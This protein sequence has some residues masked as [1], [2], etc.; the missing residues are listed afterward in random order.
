M[1]HSERIQ[2]AGLSV[3][4]PLHRFVED[5]ALP[6][7]GLDSDIFWPGVATI[8]RELTPRIRDVLATRAELQS[9][10]DNYYRAA[11]GRVE[12]DDS[13][14]FLTEIGYLADD[15]GEVTVTTEDVDT[16]ISVQAG[17][18]LVVPLL[19]RRYSANAVNARWG[20]LYDALYGTD[21]I[22]RSGELA[23]GAVYNP[24]RGE[25]VIA[26]VRD[27]LDAVAPLAG[28]SHRDVTGYAVCA[29]RLVVHR[30]DKDAVE[31]ADPTQFLGYRGDPDTP[32]AVVLVHNRLHVEVL[33]DRDGSVGRDD[34][35]GVNDVLIESAVTTIMDLEDSVAAVDAEDKV[36]GYTNWLEL[37]A[38][39]LVTQV[40]KNGT[41]FTRRM[42]PDRPYTRAD[43]SPATLRGRAL[44]FV[45][46][47]GHLMTS[48]AILDGD[49]NAVP[50]GILDAI[51][52]GLGSLRDLQRRTEL[53]NSLT[54]SMY[55]VK[56]K[57]H[58]FEEVALTVDTFSR[59]E[60]LLGL[61][62][63]T[64][65]L[66]IM[67]EERR[68][69]VNLRTCL[70]AA[71]DR[72][73]FINTGFLDRT[74]DEIHTS[75]YAGPMVR[76][77]EMKSQPWIEAYEALNVDIGIRS[78]LP[79]RGQI[80]KGMWAMPDLMADMLEQKIEQP[81]QGATTAWVPS[82]TAATLHALHYHQVDV[83]EVQQELA[84]RSTIDVRELLQV[85]LA[86]RTYSSEE[87]QAEI[88]NNIQGVLGY[89][90]RWVDQ[91]IGCSKVPDINDVALME[92]RATCRIS[93]QH[94]ANWL[95]HDVV[96]RDQ[97]ED[98][99]R[100]MARKVD[101]QNARDPDYVPMAPDYDGEAFLAARA[102]ILE[103]ASQPSG[104]TEP[105]LHHYRRLVKR[106]MRG[107]S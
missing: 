68:T 55:V 29:G 54:G 12:D 18:Q 2:V 65:K 16:E 6:D 73:V 78:G 28:A 100:R 11:P 77:A 21:I 79:G 97:V 9:K 53:R 39:T 30:D 66:G 87:R 25:A 59:V 88:D 82:P 38:G 94:V 91:G 58:G 84:S 17:P 20:S 41:T 44:L 71:S 106:R 50:E 90:V 1:S 46:Q 102:L 43:G 64:I 23:P 67:D 36:L 37:M 98:S 48:D 4:T 32:E 5:V 92:D 61:P 7:S 56:P 99:L 80:G 85:P 95:M 19:N 101:D 51:M 75:M 31:L 33:I 93:S 69:S 3:A 76:K 40:T 70:R 63:L 26:R 35:A 13:L 57:M 14:D 45:R 89:V 60:E 72:V 15:A 104:Y 103:G 52:T 105:I 62:P 83:F 8:F 86:T 42:N 96:T 34:P 27:F 24:I 10:M 49:G 81:R 22:D 47:V 107:A 74:G